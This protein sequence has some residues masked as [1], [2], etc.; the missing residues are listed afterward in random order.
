M[1][2]SNSNYILTTRIFI[3]CMGVIYLIA[4]ASFFVQFEGL[5]GQEGILPFADY[6]ASLKTNLET[7]AYWLVPTI[8]WLS[9]SDIFLYSQLIVSIIFSALLIAGVL[10][11]VS[12]L[13]LWISY[14]SIVNIGQSFMSFQWDILLIEAGFLTIL[15]SPIKLLL[16]LKDNKSPHI[17]LI[18]LFKLLLFKL[19]FSSGIGKLLSGD[20]T[21]RSLTAL[22]FHYF[23]QPL[24]N[25]VAWH[26]HHLPEWFHKSSVAMML[27]IEIIVPFFFFAPG[28]LR[29]LAGFFTIGLQIII[30][31]TGNYTFFNLLTIV[32]CLFLFD[33]NFFKG[34]YRSNSL[35]L[36]EERVTGKTTCS[37][38]K[39]GSLILVFFVIVSLSVIQFSLRYLGVRNPPQF[40]N[41]AVLY[42]SSYHIVNNYG[43]FTVMTTTRKEII[44]EGSNDGRNWKTYEF[45][46]K[47][48]DLKGGLHIVA[49]HQPRLDW[50]M[51]F[52]ALGDYRR[53]HWFV[54]LMY[55]IQQGAPEV[56]ALL[57]ENPF[58]YKPP[59]YLRAQLYD[60]T[61]TN[62]GEKKRTGDIWKR[63]YIGYYMPVLRSR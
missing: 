29:Y 36:K 58:P 7:R 4:F 10:P 43:L 33:D 24:P 14:L 23:T 25:H 57:K 56:L 59:R 1:Q 54:N 35:L 32:L 51:W 27:F 48:S 15:I 53:N 38:I 42:T 21:W 47:P 49:P 6:L 9:S 16:K 11:F 20:E 18:L 28:R 62:T 63:S 45:R 61:F 2:F 12:S 19:M 40:L 55:R 34:F 41:R 46:Y 31:A 22:N 50:Q 5:I 26:V 8:S 17:L 13:M 39:L 44:I 30:M 3:R 37:R 52:A 60:Y